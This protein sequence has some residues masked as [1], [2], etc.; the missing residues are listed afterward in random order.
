[1]QAFLVIA[2]LDR[3]D[4]ATAEI[5]LAANRTL[6]G[7][8]RSFY[9]LSMEAGFAEAQ[10]DDAGARA[11]LELAL[12][13]SAVQLGEKAPSRLQQ[14]AHL[15]RVMLRQG[16]AR[17]AVATCAESLTVQRSIGPTLFLAVTLNALALAAELCGQI[18]ESA[19][20]LAAFDMLGRNFSS[21]G[22]GLREA[23]QGAVERV[24]ATLGEEAFAE[25]WAAGHALSPDEAIEFGLEVAAALQRLLAT[26]TDAAAL[27]T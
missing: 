26:D 6:E 2:A 7:T 11:F 20:L 13:K 23:Q 19:R 1:M 4:V 15:A 25:A 9:G 3:G 10:G 21:A 22:L 16:D 12:R 5:L 17:A 27:A 14:M 18:V 8:G 24:R